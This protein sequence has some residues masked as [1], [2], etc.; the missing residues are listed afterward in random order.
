MARLHV[1]AIRRNHPQESLY[2]LGRT[3]G[4]LSADRLQG[5]IDSL[6]TTIYDQAFEDLESF[7]FSDKIQS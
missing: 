7:L 6:Y 3:E 5:H 1:P 2:T 4:D